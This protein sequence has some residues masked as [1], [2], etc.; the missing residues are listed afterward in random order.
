MLENFGGMLT[1]SALIRLN[2]VARSGMQVR[3]FAY[4]LPNHALFFIERLLVVVFGRK[5]FRL[6]RVN[7]FI[8]LCAYALRCVLIVA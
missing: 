1:A 7:R 5:H 4:S 8:A 2:F 3:V 6:I